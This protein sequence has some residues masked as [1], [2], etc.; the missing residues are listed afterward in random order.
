MKKV[1]PFSFCR[2]QKGLEAMKRAEDIQH[3]LEEFGNSIYRL[4]FYMLH[5][6]QDAQD[7][8]QETMIKYME[9]SPDFDTLEQ[10]KAWLLRVANHI[11]IDIL[12]FR[13][14]ERLMDQKDEE[15]LASRVDRA[16]KNEGKEKFIRLIF[17][18]KEKLRNVLYLYYYEE[19]STEEIAKILRI[20]NSAVRKRLER[21]RYLLKVR[22][23]E[24]QNET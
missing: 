24:G 10:E 18:L 21:G 11:C 1:I 16:G 15:M 13:K 20:S 4:S 12:R 14:K 6:E 23:Q 19:Y 2:L 8:V 5:S 22:L 7:V 9:K 3:A 17:S